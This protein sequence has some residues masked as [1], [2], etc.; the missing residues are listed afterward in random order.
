MKRGIESGTALG[1]TTVA[2]LITAAAAH[3]AVKSGGR[4]SRL[5]D[6][7]AHLVSGI[8]GPI[9]LVAIGAIAFVAMVRR[10]AGLAIAAIGVGMLAGLFIYA[11]DTAQQTFQGIYQALF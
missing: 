4:V 10:E 11:P 8:V 2:A 9:L 1:L 6:N 5:G 7:T 3:A